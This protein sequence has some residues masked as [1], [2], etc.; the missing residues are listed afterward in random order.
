MASAVLG[1]GDLPRGLHAGNFLFTQ[2]LLLFIICLLSAIIGFSFAKRYGLPGFGDHQ[3]FFRIL[4]ALLVIGGVVITLSYFFFDRRF[5]EASPL[6]YPRDLLYLLSM[7]LKGAFTE[8]VILRLC[9]VT[10]AVGFLKSKKGGVLLVAV[11]APLLTIKYFHFVGMEVGFNYLFVTQIVLSFTANLFLGYLFV[12]HGLLS[13]MA[14]KLF[15]DMKYFVI[16]W[17]I[18][19]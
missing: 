17:F 19:G 1:G 15:L 16:G 7:P 3:R 5:F 12:V 6:S 18:M 2:V 10:L 13:A 9:M 4:P 14:F 11:A 8:E